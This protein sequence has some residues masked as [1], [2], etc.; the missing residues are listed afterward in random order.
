[1]TVATAR[2]A[3]PRR[4]LNRSGRLASIGLRRSEQGMDVQV[5]LEDLARAN[6]L[7]AARVGRDIALDAADDRRRFV[8]YAAVEH[9]IRHGSREQQ[10]L[11]FHS[12][13]AH[14]E[15]DELVEDERRLGA[16]KAR[17]LHAVRL[18]SLRRIFRD[19]IMPLLVGAAS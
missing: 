3:T 12:L 17:E 13:V 16:K 18:A 6:A 14:V 2:Q 19:E 9:A 7:E 11:A 15:H 10:L 4:S 1:M 5:E 8:K